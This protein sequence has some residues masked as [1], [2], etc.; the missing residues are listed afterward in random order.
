MHMLCISRAEFEE[1]YKQAKQ[2]ELLEA[3]IT[4][5]YSFEEL[6]ADKT[7]MQEIVDSVN[8]ELIKN[9]DEIEIFVALFGHLGMYPKDS[10]VCFV[11]KDTID[12]R[13]TPVKTLEDL[14]SSIKEGSIT[15]FGIMS[16]DGLRQFQLKQYKGKL[17]TDDLF[18]FIEK[19]INHYGKDLGCTNLLVLLQSE[20]GDINDIDFEEL[21]KRIIGIGIKSDVEVLI[22]YNE[23]NK[24]DVINVIY[25]TL[26]TCRKERL[27]DFKWHSE[28]R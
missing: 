10:D 26:G 1:M 19:K 13:K 4:K 16:D 28:G 14:K 18:A 5:G 24:F 25:P 6:Q 2:E 23:E 12:P 21:N 27:T 8:V 9:K 22:S 7:K 17:N 15:D 11:L 3:I 20:G